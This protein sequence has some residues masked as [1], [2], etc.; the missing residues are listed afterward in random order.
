MT[1][2]HDR[3]QLLPGPTVNQWGLYA[4]I[5]S[6]AGVIGMIGATICALTIVAKFERIDP[7]T[8][9]FVGLVIGGFLAAWIC[10]FLGD[11]KEKAERR[12]RYT[13]ATQGNNDLPRV[14]HQTGIVMRHASQ[15]NLTRAEWESATARVRAF[16]DESSKRH[17]S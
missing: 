2:E 12:A 10:N 11:Q 1:N 3:V 6:A 5:C 4:L 14:H 9:V 8:I 15:P 13:T 7:V 16:K 17:G